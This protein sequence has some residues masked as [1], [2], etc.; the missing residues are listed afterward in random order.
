MIPFSYSEYFL[1][2]EIKV[3]LFE[4]NKM[5]R[6]SLEQ[7]IN[8][9]DGM[10]CTGAFPD[11]NKLIDHMQT[12]DPDVV[13]MDINMPGISGIEAVKLIKKNFQRCGY[14][15]KRYLTTMIKFLLPYVPELRDI[16]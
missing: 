16:C 15:C 12:A 13:M 14:L 7:L 3:A 8:N 2:M 6:E 4:D 9:A 11:A 1:P 5:L 10:I